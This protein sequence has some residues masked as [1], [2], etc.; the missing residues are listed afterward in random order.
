MGTLIHQGITVGGG[1]SELS[2]LSD[3]NISNP[4]N[5][6]VL[7]YDSTSQKWINSSGG[8]GSSTLADLTDTSI[9]T[10]TTGQALVYS[11]IGKWTN[12]TLPSVSE[13]V[14][15]NNGSELRFG[16]DSNGKYGYIKPGESTVTPFVSYSEVV[17]PSG[18]TTVTIGG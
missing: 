16:V 8:G 1:A 17:N 15:M 7:K 18:G 9:A 11:S 6:Q 5:E 3:T 10:P 2:G 13:G 14:E 12:V 4:Q